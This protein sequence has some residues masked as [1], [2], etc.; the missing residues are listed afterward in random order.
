MV[1][2]PGADRNELAARSDRMA[3]LVAKLL[4]QTARK[5]S[6]QLGGITVAAADPSERFA[7]ISL[8]DIN[9]IT[10]Y[11]RDNALTML[12]P[13][14]GDT[15]TKAA[16][17]QAAA[18]ADVT[19]AA[20]VIL[21]ESEAAVRYV[22]G[23]RNRLVG[24]GDELWAHAREGLTEGLAAGET[25]PQ[26]SKRVRDAA[27]VT[28]PRGTVIARTEIVGASNAGS[29]ASM[30][31]AD[32]SDMTKTW[33]ATGDSRTRPSHRDADGQTVGINDTFVVGGE[34]ADRPLDPLLSAAEAVNCRCTMT[35]D[36]PEGAVAP[37]FVEEE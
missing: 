33:L 12:V 36:I 9:G 3:D 4:G 20:P 34:S 19:G 7:S 37:E 23:A 31:A 27:G 17:A 32:I 14:A 30:R 18:L 29:I 11:W 8:D 26:L 6:R 1:S 16:Q 21:D 5:F 22:A 28:A 10:D 13:Y 25:V 24:I 15:Y 2:I 35:Y